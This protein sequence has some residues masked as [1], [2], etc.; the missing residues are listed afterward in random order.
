MGINLIAG[1]PNVVV[2][3]QTISF[4][5]AGITA[6]NTAVIFLVSSGELKS[7]VPG[8]LINGITG[9]VKD[10]GYYI[11]PLI[12]ID[13]QS[14]SLP[15]IVQPSVGVPLIIFTGESN[16]GGYALNSQAL[17]GEIAPRSSIQILNNN[18]MLF[19]ALDIGT[20][21]IIGHAGLAP[22]QTHGWELMLANR[23][24][25]GTFIPS[26]CYLV[27]TGQ[28]GS[29]IEQWAEGAAE[30]YWDI[31]QDRV[32]TAITLLTTLT[33]SAPTPYIFYSQGINNALNSGTAPAWITNTLAHFDKIRAKY[34][35]VPIVMTKF[36]STHPILNAAIDEL[37]PQRSGVYS[38]FTEDATLRDVNHWD[39]T[40]MKLVSSR[41]QEVLL[42]NYAI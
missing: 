36:M 10:K 15:P 38:V 34:G 21:N 4:D 29:L 12:D 37:V 28:G 23:V 9:F 35:N 20:N 8:R 5:L 22:D 7:Y 16:S 42:Q 40:G 2:A 33:G 14:W 31:F 39:Y 13:L 1:R 26:P 18:T 32:D 24:E 30:G 25:A 19:E 11:V 41:M 17:S 3:K 27:K 6:I